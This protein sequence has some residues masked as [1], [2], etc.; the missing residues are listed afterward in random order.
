MQSFELEP[1]AL[2]QVLGE[3]GPTAGRNGLDDLQGLVDRVVRQGHPGRA[4]ESR[5]L[6]DERAAQSPG[7]RR[8]TDDTERLAREGGRPG[9]GAEQDVFLPERP[10]NVAGQ[11]GWNLGARER[12]AQPLRPRAHAAVQLAE[13]DAPERGVP[14]DARRL[15]RREDLRDAAHRPPGS[16]LR[17]DLVFVVDAVLEREHRRVRAQDRPEPRGRVLR[18]ER[19][20]AEE[21]GVGA[22]DALETLDRRRPHGG[23]ALDR[24]ADREPGAA[25]RLEVG[26]ASDHRHLGSPAQELRAEVAADATRPH[27]HDVHETYD[28]SE[29]LIVGRLAA[30]FPDD[31]VL[32]EECGATAGRS[33]R[34]WIIDPLDGTTNYAHG[35]PIFAVSIG[36]EIDKRVELGVVFDPN[37]DELFVAERGRGATV[38]DQP[39]T[40]STAA[41]LD[42]SLLATGFPYNIREAKDNNLTEYAA[43]SVRARAVRRMGSAVLYLA[44][45][46]TGRLDGYWE[47][48]LGPW[49]V[50]AGSLLVEEAG[51]RVTN[52]TG[53]AL[54]IDAPAL[55]ASNGRIHDAILGVLGASR[56]GGPT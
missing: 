36:L 51:G 19:L 28:T 2:Q 32:G 31:A 15:D 27:D 55:V 37:L 49:D 5:D 43:F 13:D 26:A 17:V 9:D 30:A 25:D 16:H 38:N 39:L 8:V 18:V 42:E 20:D 34:R 44:W 45:L 35:L 21:N 7:R 23:V 14:D 3:R 56:G 48:R 12:V 53:G 6:L 22:R 10:P 52:L 47:L 54:D 41:T 40:V 46:A 24:G 1:F 11:L 4:R 50:A 29:E 33:G